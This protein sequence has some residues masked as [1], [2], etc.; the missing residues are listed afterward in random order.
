MWCVRECDVCAST[1]GFY[2]GG[3]ALRLHLSQ[4]TYAWFLALI[5]GRELYHQCLREL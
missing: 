4:L 1:E 2:A 3:A 5:L